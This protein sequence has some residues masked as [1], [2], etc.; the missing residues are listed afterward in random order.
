MGTCTSA[1]SVVYASA[2]G[3]TSS[4][5]TQLAPCT[6]DRAIAI[7]DTTRFI[8]RMT[9]GSY[10]GSETI[11]AKQIVIDGYGSSLA[12][13]SSANAFLVRDSATATILGLTLSTTTTEPAIECD[14]GS[15]TLSHVSINAFAES[16]VSNPP[17]GSCAITIDQSD[18][19]TTYTNLPAVLV[20]TQVTVVI[21]RSV[22]DG[23]DGIVT[24]AD[25]S[26]IRLENSIVKNQ[27]GSDGALWGAGPIS[28][29]FTTF[30]DSPIKCGANTSI[31]DSI[32]VATAGDV[33]TL[34]TSTH[35]NVNDSLLTPQNGAYVGS[36]DH[37]NTDPLFVDKTNGNYMLAS[38]SP[39]IDAVPLGATV[40][41]VDLVGTTRPQGPR[42]DLGAYEYKP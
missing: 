6:L 17:T 12:A 10:L 16:V 26:A 35:C 5:C 36:G 23:G 27:N 32:L 3:S 30:V 39:A 29:S 22:I 37:L 8:I 19:H 41:A 14:G 34:G 28:A 9:P 21:Q 24:Y 31:V 13:P 2:A 1:D 7:A 38:G 11:D 25:S 40:P 15:V 20:T 4:N 18:F 33:V 42:A